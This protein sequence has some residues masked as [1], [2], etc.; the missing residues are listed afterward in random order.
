KDRIL[1]N[2]DDPLGYFEKFRGVPE[3]LIVDL[4]KIYNKRLDVLLG[5]YEADKL[6]D[7]PMSVELMNGNFCNSLFVVFSPC[8][9]NV[10]YSV[11]AIDLLNLFSN[12]A[13]KACHKDREFHIL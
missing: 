6:V 8:G 12:G 9:F 5:I 2:L 7:D 3:H 1:R 4:C 11:H 13:F 10:Q